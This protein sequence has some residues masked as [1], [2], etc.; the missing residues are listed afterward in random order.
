VTRSGH[1]A[2]LVCLS[3]GGCGA[4]PLDAV[5]MDPVNLAAGQVA[6]WTFD[7]GSG[8][9]VSDRSGNGHHGQ[10][11]AGA[12]TSTGRFG[13][14]L[15]LN[16]GDHV[17]VPNFPQA[18]T[19]WTVSVWI[20][21]SLEQLTI[22]RTQEDWVTVLSAESVFAGGWQLHVDNRP[23]YDRFD[24]AY[25]A[26]STV[27]DYVV[28]SCECI[29]VGQWIHLTAVFD[30]LAGELTFYRDDRVIDRRPMPMPILPG[31]PTLYI[32]RWNME[33]RFLTATIDD[34][35]I[36]SRALTPAEIALLS[37]QPPPVPAVMP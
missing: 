37:R 8:A 29:D 36:W 7:D 35:A 26:G 21:M 22:G 4:G 13:G 27:N 19:A 10:L 9:V 25:W 31:D 12:W 23:G 6:H 3:L 15:D 18:T 24:A 16:A 34:F 11:T 33:G 30:G 5:T 1:V 2:L 14:A 28:A 17:T 20:R 32:G